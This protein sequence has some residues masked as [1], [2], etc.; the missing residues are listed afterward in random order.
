MKVQIRKE[1]ATDYDQVE[2]VI[3][4]A[5][6]S[7]DYS[8]QTEHKLVNR[9]RNSSAFIPDLS[10]VAISDDQIVGH[11]LVTRIHIENEHHRVFPSLALAP[12]SV[13]PAFQ[14]QGI[15]RQL[16]EEAH[17]IA[18]RLGHGSIILLGHA[19]YYPRFGYVPTSHYGI[20]LPFE[21]PEENCMV[22]EL[23]ED[24]LAGVQGVVVYPSAFFE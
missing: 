6:R 9:L 3:E 22:L 17:R 23:M 4:S 7:V 21:A 14:K 20:R 8:D 16:I 24:G 19:D 10:L 2:Q 13:L 18:K 5:F 1:R 12:V 11:I 15:G